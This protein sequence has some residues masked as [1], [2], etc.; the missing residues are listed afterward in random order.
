M[1]E[2]VPLPPV[3]HLIRIL[4]LIDQIEE[5]LKMDLTIAIKA[6]VILKGLKSEV[7]YGELSKYL[8]SLL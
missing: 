7:S 1:P 8:K 4:S 6:K 2:L 5:S 3:D